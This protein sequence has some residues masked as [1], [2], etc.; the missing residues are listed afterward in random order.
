MERQNLI[1]GLQIVSAIGILAIGLLSYFG[2]ST[3]DFREETREGFASLRMEMNEEFASFRMEMKD[4]LVSIRKEMKDGFTS[5]RTEMTEGFAS[6]RTEMREMNT[7]LARVEGYL[8]M[9]DELIK[10]VP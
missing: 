1:L 10:P 6:I 8:G 5:V 9:T 7:R 2:Q 4:E 3:D